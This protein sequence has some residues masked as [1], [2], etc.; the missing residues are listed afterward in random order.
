[1]IIVNAWLTLHSPLSNT[2]P[3]TSMHE[4]VN[5]WHVIKTREKKKKE[6]KQTL[7]LTCDNKQACCRCPASEN[8]SG[9]TA[10]AVVGLRS[11][12]RRG[13][14]PKRAKGAC[15]KPL[16]WMMMMG[17]CVCNSAYGVV[18]MGLR[19]LSFLVEEGR[20]TFGIVVGFWAK[21]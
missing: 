14:A 6:T 4:H 7:I 15:L 20:S 3:M 10:I 19:V 13:D 5:G 9:K 1:M 8:G 11:T 17:V 2:T 16:S 12:T 18:H 21:F